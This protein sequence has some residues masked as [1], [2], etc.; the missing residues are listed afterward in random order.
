MDDNDRLLLASMLKAAVLEGME[1]HRVN[2]HLAMEV[3]MKDI[4]KS[5]DDINGKF[6]WF[7]GAAAGISAAVTHGAGKI[8]EHLSGK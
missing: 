4:E 2:D 8:M 5:T 3:R 6:K 7:A 1:A